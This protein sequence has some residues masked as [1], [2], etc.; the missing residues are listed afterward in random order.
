MALTRRKLGEILQKWGLVNEQQLNEA[1]QRFMD[2]NAA[3]LAYMKIL[4]QRYNAPEREW[5][6]RD[7]AYTLFNNRIFVVAKCSAFY[8]RDDPWSVGIGA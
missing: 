2:M 6:L 7:W 5:T 3:Y 1:Y 4:R 8:D